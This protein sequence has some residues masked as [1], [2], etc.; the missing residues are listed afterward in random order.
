MKKKISII[1]GGR[2]SEHEVSIRSAF[3][4]YKALD[5]NKFD[6]ILIG[7][8]KQGTWYLFSEKNMSEFTALNDADLQNQTP[9]TLI[10]HQGKPFILNLNT[11]EKNS[12]DCAFPIVH[13]TN[14]EDGTLQG[15]FKMTN[16]PFIGCGV[17][18]S[19]ICMDKEY[20]KIAMTFA[21]IPNSK[22]QV[23]R[24]N[25]KNDFTQISQNLGLPFFIKPANA[26]SSVGVHKIKSETDFQQKLA[27]AFQSITKLL[28]KN[29]F[30]AA[31]LNVL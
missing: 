24:K 13:G 27:N 22:F 11:H 23:L 9:V 20:M 30:R 10:S 5:K 17:L 2:S 25:E 31:K 18:G 14:G 28:P 15:L 21:N 8:S 19:A 16:V 3:N 6:P 1:F 26:G 29:L 7:I 12:F 4:I